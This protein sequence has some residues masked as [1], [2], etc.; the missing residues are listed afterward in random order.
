MKIHIVLFV[1]IAA[2]LGPAVSGAALPPVLV[3]EDIRVSG[4][5]ISGMRPDLARRLIHRR[6]DRPI[7]FTYAERHWDVSTWVLAGSAAFR[8][9][10]DGALQAEPGSRLKLPVTVQPSW[11]R[12]YVEYL[13]QTYYRAPVNAKLVGL[14]KLRPY[15]APARYGVRV[16]KAEMVRRI[17]RNLLEQRRVPIKLATEAI[18]PERLRTDLGAEIVIRRLSNRLYLYKGGRFWRSFGVATG[19]SY[20]PTPTGFFWIADK[21]RWPAWYP[22]NSPWAKGLKPIPPG[23]NNP[24]GT[25]WMGLNTYGVGIHGTPNP[26]SIGYSASHGCIRMHIPNAEWLF[27]RVVEKTPVYIVDA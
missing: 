12:H 3:P 26:A 23:P 16:R 15:V 17:T 18:A 2:V 22:P 1:A 25:R 19:S 6:F 9:A 5:D 13:S 11:V 14:R 21:Q 8:D 20:Y 4:V 7:R 10:V 27:E 24:L